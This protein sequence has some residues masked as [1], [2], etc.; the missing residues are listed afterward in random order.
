MTVRK[1]AIHQLLHLGGAVQRIVRRKQTAAIS[2][3]QIAVIHYLRLLR[4]NLTPNESGAAKVTTNKRLGV[5]VTV[6]ERH[7]AKVARA[8]Q[9][10]EEAKRRENHLYIDTHTRE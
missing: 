7:S 9:H 4:D 3:A 1:A 10:V 8:K 2:A 5:K 6:G